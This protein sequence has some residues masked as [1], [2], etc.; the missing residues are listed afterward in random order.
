MYC[1]GLSRRRTVAGGGLS[2]ETS[3][4]PVEQDNAQDV[5]GPGCTWPVQV[6][7]EWGLVGPAGLEPAT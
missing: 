6:M 5:I 7:R 4:V 2:W 1:A 3:E